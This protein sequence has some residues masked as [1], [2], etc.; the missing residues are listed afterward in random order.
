MFGF[1]WQQVKLAS[2]AGSMCK[3]SLKTVNLLEAYTLY[4]AAYKS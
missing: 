4:I 3:P 2:L 1:P